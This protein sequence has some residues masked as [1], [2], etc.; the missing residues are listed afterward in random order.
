MVFMPF[1]VLFTWLVGL[2]SLGILGSGAYILYAWYVGALVGTVYLVSGLAIVLWS[3]AGNLIILF[4]LKRRGKDEPKALRNGTVKRLQR[5]DG[6]EIQVEFYG[7]TDGQPIILTHGWGPNSTVWYY[8][9]RQ[10]GQHFRLILWDLPGL[11]KSTGPHNQDYSLEKYARDLEAIVQ[12]TGDRPVIL[13]GHSI[14]GMIVLTFCRLF[15][16]HLTRRVSGLI[17]VDTTYTNP[18][19]TAIFSKVLQAL[20]KPLLEPLLHLT[21]WLFPLVWCMNWL[22]YFNGSQLVGMWL[23]G[24][25]GT[26]TRGQLNFSTLLSLYGSPA[27]LARGTLA[28][29]AYDATE[30]LAHIQVPVQIIVGASDIVTVPPTSHYMHQAIP[31]S[32][33]VTLQ[34]A[35]HMG[36][37]EQNQRFAEVVSSFSAV[38][39]GL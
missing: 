3:I 9:K 30:T 37:M 25:T 22:N 6:S 5:P 2:L 35:G 39:I 17:L 20:Q 8:A 38:G 29:L 4:L 24:F 34:R 33:L 21:I 11:G 19:K 10:L 12:L 32:E 18:L 7:P 31:H 36:L 16:E 14:G 13:L 23:S 28:M 1:N 26:E 15:P 27:V